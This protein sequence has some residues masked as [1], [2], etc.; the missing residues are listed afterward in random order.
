MIALA[1]ENL[2]VFFIECEMRIERAGI[3]MVNLERISYGPSMTAA[4]AMVPSRRY[5]LVSKLYPLI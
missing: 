4:F 1:T 3:D 5:Y 2:K